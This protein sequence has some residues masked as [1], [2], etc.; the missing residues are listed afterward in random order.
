MNKGDIVKCRIGATAHTLQVVAI[1]GRV[2][3]VR[4]LGLKP[5]QFSVQVHRC[6]KIERKA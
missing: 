3:V 6:E 2:A 5:R 4:T 1:Y